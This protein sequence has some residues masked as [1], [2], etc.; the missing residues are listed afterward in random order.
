MTHDGCVRTPFKL[1]KIFDVI[2]PLYYASK[3]DFKKKW[4]RFEV[5]THCRISGQV[6]YLIF[7]YCPR[8]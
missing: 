3:V 7:K 6:Y 5:Q 1:A 8:W 4:M 2:L